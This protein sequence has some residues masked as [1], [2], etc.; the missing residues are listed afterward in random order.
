MESNK[1]ILPEKKIIINHE[2]ITIKQTNLII[3]QL[4]E[5]ICKIKLQNSNLVT[6]F[7]CSIKYKNEPLPVLITCDHSFNNKEDKNLLENL[8]KNKK[9]IKLYLNDDSIEKE[10]NFSFKRKVY[11]NKAYDTTIIEILPKVDKIKIKN[12]LS[13]DEKISFN[14]SYYEGNSIYVL[15]YP[16]GNEASVSFGIIKDLENVE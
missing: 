9:I 16:D 3:E 13:F 2:P 12:Y 11:T 5:S 15:Q 1:V 7:F 4:K 10:I 14:Y 6:G 8:I